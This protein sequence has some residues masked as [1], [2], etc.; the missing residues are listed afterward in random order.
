MYS[1]CHVQY[2]LYI[3][4]DN[5]IN[6]V[7]VSVVALLTLPLAGNNKSHIVSYRSQHTWTE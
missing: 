3:V 7:S 5:D 1:R 2:G 6:V 4:C